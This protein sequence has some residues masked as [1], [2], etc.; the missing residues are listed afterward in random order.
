M[1]YSKDTIL[2]G[3]VYEVYEGTPEEIIQLMN[4]MPQELKGGE[5][6]K[7][8][9]VKDFVTGLQETAKNL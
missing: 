9:C 6:G 4:L 3:T 7:G 1:Q 5:I 2:D 8:I